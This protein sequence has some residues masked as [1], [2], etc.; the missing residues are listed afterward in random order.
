MAGGLNFI[1]LE[2]RGYDGGWK[3]MR[4]RGLGQSWQCWERLLGQSNALLG[5]AW[6][7]EGGQPTDGMVEEQVNKAAGKL[8][9]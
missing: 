3:G 7:S 8:Q 2:M 4:R 9:Q 5:T 1:P 6:R